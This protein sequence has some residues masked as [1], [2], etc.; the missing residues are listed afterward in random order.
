MVTPYGS[1]S[2]N[3][4]TNN[5]AKVDRA[6]GSVLKDN[7]SQYVHLTQGNVRKVDNTDVKTVLIQTF[8]EECSIHISN[9]EYYFLD[10]KQVIEFIKKD[11]TD[12]LKNRCPSNVYDFSRILI[13]RALESVL[14]D[15]VN[16]GIAMG[17]IRG[18]ISIDGKETP[19]VGS[20]VVFIVT[21]K[22]GQKVILLDPKTD[23][24]FFPNSLS[25]YETIFI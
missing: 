15:K 10:P 17:E 19:K 24:C 9:R 7:S 11:Q 18:V 25:I 12:R 14:L 2:A 3:T 8:G 16:L 22:T 4:N 6:K 5:R 21:H 13:G 20:F 1:I 23:Q